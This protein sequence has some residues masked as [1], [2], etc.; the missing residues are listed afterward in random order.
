M[1]AH[2][3][4]KTLM[5]LGFGAIL[6]LAAWRAPATAQSS[7]AYGV[8]PAAF[9]AGGGQLI[10]HFDQGDGRITSLTII[11]SQ[12][13]VIAVYHLVRDTGEIQLKSVRPIRWDLAMKD[14]NT[15]GLLPEE[16]RKGIE[17]GTH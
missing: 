10:T 6:A 3:M 2:A 13:R 15:G 9:G 5:W 4:A 12:A 11:D 17:A 16:I 1:E 8:D 7:S 14:Y